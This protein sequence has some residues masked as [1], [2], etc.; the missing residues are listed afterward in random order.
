MKFMTL[1]KK[2]WCV[3]FVIMFEQ[4]QCQIHFLYS[5]KKFYWDFFYIKKSSFLY[6]N[7]IIK[8][9]HRHLLEPKGFS[10]FCFSL[11]KRK[12]K[13]YSN[14]LA[15]SIQCSSSLLVHFIQHHKQFLFLVSKQRMLNVLFL[16]Q[17][18][19]NAITQ[20]TDL[21]LCLE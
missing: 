14:R 1:P 15:I 13:F 4:T 12:F 5:F 16:A 6:L 19:A 2:A 20:E 11:K 9:N 7:I 17:L 18:K 10:V 8:E 21:K 3:F